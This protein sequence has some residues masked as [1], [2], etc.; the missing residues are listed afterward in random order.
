MKSALVPHGMGK[1]TGFTLVEILIVIAILGILYSVALPAYTEHMQRSRRADIQQDYCNTAPVL[2]VFIH[3][4]A[5]TLMHLQLKILTITPLPTQQQI[6]Y[7]V[8]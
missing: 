5:A 4:M 2:N 7:Q 8:L 3:E 6:K 1:Q